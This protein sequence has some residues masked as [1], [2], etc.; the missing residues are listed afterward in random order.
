MKT[1]LL[2]SFVY[3]TIDPLTLSFGYGS[4]KTGNRLKTLSYVCIAK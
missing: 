3:V 1:S 2:L 4:N